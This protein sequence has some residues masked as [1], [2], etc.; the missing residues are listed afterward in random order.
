[1]IAVAPGAVHS[2][3]DCRNNTPTADSMLFNIEHVRNKTSISPDALA[4]RQS[5]AQSSGDK[6]AQAMGKGMCRLRGD[7]LRRWLSLMSGEPQP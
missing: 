1:M 7:S 6:Y 2:S 4:G 5:S 3:V